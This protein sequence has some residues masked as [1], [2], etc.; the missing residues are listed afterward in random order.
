M[1]S[2]RSIIYG[3]LPQGDDTGLMII[4]FTTVG[5]GGSGPVVTGMECKAS[6]FSADSSKNLPELVADLAT[7]CVD[8]ERDLPV[9]NGHWHIQQA[10][11]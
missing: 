2:V 1:L 3:V 6:V 10:V 9:T 11:P 5:T 4:L 8:T 7:L